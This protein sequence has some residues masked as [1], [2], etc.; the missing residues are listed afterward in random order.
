MSASKLS[1]PTNMDELVAKWTSKSGDTQGLRD[2]L[3]LLKVLRDYLY[4]Q[5]VPFPDEPGY[6]DRLFVW[7]DQV[8]HVSHK[9]TLFKLA[10]WLL[11]VGAEEMKSLYKSSFSGIV[12]RWIIDQSQIDL[13]SSNFSGE[14][15][16][17]IDTTFF[18]SVAGMDIGTYCRINGIQQSYRPDF[19]EVAAI[20][21]TDKLISYLRSNDYERVV[22]V[23]DYVGGGSQMREAWRCLQHLE[24]TQ[25]EPIPLLITPIISAPK[26]LRTGNL[27]ASKSTTFEVEYPL[28]SSSCIAE[29]AA[30]GSKE[31]ALTSKARKLFTRYWNQTA[32]NKA[33]QPLYGPF[34]CDGVGSLVLTYLNCPDNV[35]PILHHKSD[36][37]KPLFQRASREV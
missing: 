36:S 3:E 5:Y 16:A 21:D 30:S 12:T 15:E 22:A 7:V 13:S 25:P 32:G 9:K 24:G 29:V 18:G 28:P 1:K 20:G 19:R 2:E 14:L 34:G 11:F 35:P 4:D 6:I 37:W 31:P 26:G 8:S 23:E 17:A 27:L 33:T 10:T